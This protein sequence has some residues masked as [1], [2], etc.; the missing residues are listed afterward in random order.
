MY[1]DTTASTVLPHG[2][3]GDP[4]NYYGMGYSL[5]LVEELVYLVHHI[6]RWR[7]SKLL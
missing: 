4:A 3:D 2:Q 5:A 6:A 1:D 7:S